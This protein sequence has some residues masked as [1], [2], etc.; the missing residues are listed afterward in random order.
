MSKDQFIDFSTGIESRKIE[1]TVGFISLNQVRLLNSLN[2]WRK[3]LS[4]DLVDPYDEVSTQIEVVL[5]VEFAQIETII[6]I[7]TSK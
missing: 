6:A 5:R 4:G 7:R 2:S 1:V 3:G